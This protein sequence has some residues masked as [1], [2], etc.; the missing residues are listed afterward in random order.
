MVLFLQDREQAPFHYSTYNG[1]EMLCKVYVY[2]CLFVCG[3]PSLS[4][5]FHSNWDVTIAG[6]GLEF[7]L[8]FARQSWSLGNE[9]SLACYTYCDTGHSYIMIIFDYPNGFIKCIS[10]PAVAARWV[11]ALAPQ[12][13][14]CVLESQTRQT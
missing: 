10:S 7:C 5:I 8:T 11:R 4:I 13:E 12:V 14:G 2:F 1:R 6:D 9:S 3:F